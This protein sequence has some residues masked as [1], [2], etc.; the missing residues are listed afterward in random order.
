[1]DVSR[2]AVNGLERGSVIEHEAVLTMEEVARFEDSDLRG[3]GAQVER[4]V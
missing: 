4:R 3:R 2:A 1:M